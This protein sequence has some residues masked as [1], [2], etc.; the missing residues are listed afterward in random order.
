MTLG[1]PLGNQTDQAGVFGNADLSGVLSE[2]N[3]AIG[4][5]AGVASPTDIP[6]AYNSSP[7][8]QER[9]LIVGQPIQNRVIMKSYDGFFE[10]GFE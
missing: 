3:S 9:T 7:K 10:G 5:I 1:L 6:Y 8:P 4:S 2:N